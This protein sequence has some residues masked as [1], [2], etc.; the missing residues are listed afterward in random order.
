MPPECLFVS[1]EIVVLLRETGIM[2]D[3][4]ASMVRPLTPP[5]TSMSYR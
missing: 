1:C 3:Q 2:F 5:E 4:A